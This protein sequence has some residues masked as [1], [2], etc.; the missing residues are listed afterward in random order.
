MQ[1]EELRSRIVDVFLCNPTTATPMATSAKEKL[2]AHFREVPN[3]K[4]KCLI[5]GKVR[6]F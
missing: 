1:L 4:M 3:R 2:Q 6:L 5:K